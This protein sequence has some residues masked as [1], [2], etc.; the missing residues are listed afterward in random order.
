MTAAETI[1]PPSLVNRLRRLVKE[2][3]TDTAYDDDA[4]REY[5]CQ[6]PKESG[7]WC[8]YA[9][10]RDIWEEKAAC[11]ADCTDFSADGRSFKLSGKY[12]HYMK[13]ARYHGARACVKTICL[14]TTSP[15]LH[16]DIYSPEEVVINAPW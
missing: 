2:C 12:D 16:D 4:L 10:A 11:V 9:A 14:T 15:P 7:G 13:M 5:L 3:A 8:I 1:P 6:Y